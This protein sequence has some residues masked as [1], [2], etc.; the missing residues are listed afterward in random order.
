MHGL[1]R[2]YVLVFKTLLE[3]LADV[4]LIDEDTKSILTDHDNKEIFSNMT[5]NASG[6]IWW[7]N[8]QLMQVQHWTEFVLPLAMFRIKYFYQSIKGQA[9]WY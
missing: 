7:P 3:D 4:T 2:P 5:S 8:F 1:R 6:D 9:W